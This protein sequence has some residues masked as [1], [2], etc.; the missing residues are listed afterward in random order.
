ME[1]NLLFYIAVILFCGLAFGR[2]VKQIKL[3]NVTGYLLAG[4]V[5]GPFLLKL[6]PA[7]AV[8]SMSVVSDM[9]LGFIAF[10][11]GGEF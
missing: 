6:L 8:E 11:V 7:P 9:A 1:S 4:L 10:S 3:P 5:I 2:L